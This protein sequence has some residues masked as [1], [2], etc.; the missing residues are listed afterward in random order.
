[1]KKLLLRRSRYTV[2]R[3]IYGGSVGKH[4]ESISAD[5]DVVLFLND[6]KHPFDDVLTEW[7]QI[8][9]MNEGDIQIDEDLIKKTRHSIHFTLKNQ[10]VDV[11]L[12][13]ATNF[14]PRHLKVSGEDLAKVQNAGVTKVMSP[15]NYKALSSS[16]SESQ[17]Y[18]M[19]KQSEF[20]HQVQ[21]QVLL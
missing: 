11:D 8:L 14:V 7:E 18:F 21:I 6:E 4:T 5:F 17:I 3:A 13:P 12:L 9:M 16:L 10:Q 15:H 2:D 1:V 19:K 20:T